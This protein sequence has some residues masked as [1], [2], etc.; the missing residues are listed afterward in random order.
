MLNFFF[1]VGDGDSR[2]PCIGIGVRMKGVMYFMFK[3]PALRSLD[4]GQRK[5]HGSNVIYMNIKNDTTVSIYE[6]DAKLPRKQMKI[7]WITCSLTCK[8]I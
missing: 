4:E 6:L 8:V 1:G 2:I 7:T 5:N 3:F